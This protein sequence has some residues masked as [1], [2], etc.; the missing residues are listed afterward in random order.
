[1]SL[2]QNIE[3]LNKGYEQSLLTFKIIVLGDS[4]V[5]KSCLTLKAVKGVMDKN[6]KSK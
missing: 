2:G 4:F 6:Y 5:G 3:L 1:M